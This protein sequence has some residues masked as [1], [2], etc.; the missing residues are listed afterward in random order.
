M[1]PPRTGAGVTDMDP[2]AGPETNEHA[3][4]TPTLITT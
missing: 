4:L 3:K 1:R 2:E